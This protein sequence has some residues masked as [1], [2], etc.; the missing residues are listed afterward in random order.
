MSVAVILPARRHSTRLPEKLLLNRTGKTV[1]EHTLERAAAA[2]AQSNGLI[3][4]VLAA[5]DDPELLR[6]AEKAGARAVLTRAD[7]ASGTDRLAEAAGH[8]KEDLIVNWQADEPELDPA[9][10][11]QVARLLT[12]PDTRSKRV[13]DMAT[14][15]V[16][17][18][19]EE[20]FLKPNVV[21]VVTDAA[22]N[23]L[24]FSRAPIPF[25]RDAQDT[26]AHWKM[27]PLKPAFESSTSANARRIFGLHHLGLYAYRREFLR[28]FA[29]LPPARLEQLEKLE[30]LRALENGF[31]IRVGLTANHPPGIDTPEDYAA[32]VKRC[33]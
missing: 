25:V 32:F 19:D 30:Q 12:Q 23:A 28:T 5:V 21:K 31:V 6:V 2:Q 16:P 1:L 8:V 9:L 15:A 24:Y 4:T 11:Q 20:K 29:Q 27:D 3:T 18:F 14:L 26:Q 10:I 7:H 33:K 13:P 22:G 17:I